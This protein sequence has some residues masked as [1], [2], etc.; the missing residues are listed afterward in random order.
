[1]QTL[2]VD[3]RPPVQQLR[4]K[5]NVV[6]LSL[7]V[8]VAR[9]DERGQPD[10]LGPRNDQ[11]GAAELR[12]L[13]VFVGPVALVALEVVVQLLRCVAEWGREGAQ[14]CWRG[15]LLVVGV[16]SRAPR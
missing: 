5:R 1:M 10:P 7:G 15:F 4:H 14:K 8:N 11:T 12:P 16:R 2:P 9:P 13:G 6:Q 3:A